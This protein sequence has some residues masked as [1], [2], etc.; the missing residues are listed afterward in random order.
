MTLYEIEET[1][2]DL[3]SRHPGMSETLLVTLLRSGG[4]EEKN[5]QEAILL[6]RS[7]GEGEKNASA[8]KVADVLPSL[9]TIS[10]LPPP[11]D[12]KHLLMEHY[13][14]TPSRREEQVVTSEPQSR[15]K[16]STESVPN[17]KDEL[18]HNLPLRP[19][20]TS[21]HIWPFARYKDVFYGEA[22]PKVEVKEV[23]KMETEVVQEEMK[24]EQKAAAP[25]IELIAPAPVQGEK[26]IFTPPH[27]EDK[28]VPVIVHLTKGDEKMVIMAC[29]MLL[30][31]LLLLGYMYSNGRL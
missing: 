26:N 7:G 30:A 21:E 9:E 6:F 18:P 17:K 23:K 5:I 22:S 13:E 14:D 10:V 12:E 4:W 24:A 25:A 29:V 16:D 15:V 20:E 2:H 8:T 31:I 28:P 3:Q 1:L 11:A 19:F 27:A